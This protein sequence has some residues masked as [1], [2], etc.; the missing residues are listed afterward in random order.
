MFYV[1]GKGSPLGLVNVD[2]F[3]LSLKIHGGW[4]DRP[5]TLPCGWS[6]VQMSQTQVW[7]QR[8]FILD[9]EGNKL[10]T[11]LADP[12]SKD[13]INKE[14]AMLEVANRWLYYDDFLNLCDVLL[15][16]Q[17][18]VVSGV[19]RVDLCCDFELDRY[20]W[21]VFKRLA[22][23]QCYV[24]A[25]RNGVVWWKQLDKVRV[26]HQL[27][28]GGYDSAVHWK[29]YYKWLELSEGGEESMKPYIV[30]QWE[31]MG[32]DKHVVW[33]CEVSL[34]NCNRFVGAD[35]DAKIAAFDWYRDRVRLWS[36][37]YADKFVVRA[38]QGHKDKRNDSVV[39][40]LDVDGDKVIK[41]ALPSS[42]RE[43]SDPER[44]LAV[45][46]WYE[47]QQGDTKC[48]SQLMSMIQSSLQELLERPSNLYA[49]QNRYGVS[50]DEISSA[51]NPLG[52][53]S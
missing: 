11:F 25:L 1:N 42:L 6:A 21:G 47:L 45:K 37:L 36:G 28:W 4:K 18:C 14:C 13:V 30:D 23:G 44:R 52:A 12:R 49:I 22:S 24:K 26:P 41:Y 43:A 20:K 39:K 7:G 51:L 35:D 19:S 48:N 33:R 27:S 46:L 40:F 15:D 50:L 34:T 10:A 53:S 38:N 5:F 9:G 29:V 16:S 31:R 8:W 2:W 3:G 32:F 17:P